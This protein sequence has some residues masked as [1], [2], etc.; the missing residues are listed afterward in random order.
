MKARVQALE[1]DK[2]VLREIIKEMVYE[3]V[4]SG[5]TV[6]G[7][8]RQGPV[9]R[10]LGLAAAREVTTYPIAGGRF[11]TA[12]APKVEQECQFRGQ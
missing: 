12:G 9:A 7:E 4:C 10:E 8:D 2:K 5:L 1:V 6:E 3:E 11:G